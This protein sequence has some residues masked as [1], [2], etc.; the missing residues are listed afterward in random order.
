MVRFFINTQVHD[1]WTALDA[2]QITESFDGYPQPRTI[3]RELTEVEKCIWRMRDQYRILFMFDADK[4]GKMRQSLMNLVIEDFPDL[5]VKH[6]LVTD[7][8][9]EYWLQQ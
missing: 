9:H 7:T 8:S 4:V 1:F 6:G 2:G 3:Y 5:A